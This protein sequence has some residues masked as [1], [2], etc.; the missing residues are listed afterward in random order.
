LL[1]KALQTVDIRKSVSNREAFSASLVMA[2]AG[3]GDAFLYSVLPIYGESMGFSVFFIGVLL[4]VNRF[5]RIISNT[6]IANLINLL[7]MKRIL[8]LSASLAAL[9]SLIYGLK[10]G[11][12]FFLGA[13]IIWGLSYSGLKISTLNY[14]A[15]VKENAGV[16]FA[17]VHAIKSLGAILVFGFGPILIYE[18]GIEQGFIIIA[19]ISSCGILVAYRLPD[20]IYTAESRVKTSRTFQLSSM[21]VLIFFVALT[22][23]GVLVVGLSN[24]LGAEYSNKEELLA[25][26]AV[27]LLLKHVFNIIVPFLS[28]FVSLKLKTDYLFKFSLLMCIIA[29]YLI[30]FNY[31]VLGILLAFFFNILIVAYSPL[32]AIQRQH[33]HSLQAISSSSTWWDL[34]AAIGALVGIYCLN[35]F[36]IQNLFLLLATLILIISSVF[37]YD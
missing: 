11:V 29:L 5:I 10:I 14:A 13:R 17:V 25:F 1:S 12:I 33:E 6:F 19:L 18:F 4:S 21:N 24:L 3:L 15:K 9:T 16:S 7:G 27:Y 20:T 8:V 22:I 31:L 28:G 34:G 23:D 35:L 32:I 2:F 26:V 30:A 36:G 37:L